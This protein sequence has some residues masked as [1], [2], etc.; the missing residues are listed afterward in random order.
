MKNLLVITLCLV[1]VIFFA[2]CGKENNTNNTPTSTTSNNQENDIQSSDAEGA[3]DDLGISFEKPEKAVSIDTSL[4]DPSNE[5]ITFG[6]DD[7]GKVLRC[8]Y[9]Y[10]DQIIALT[11]TYNDDNTVQIYGFIDSTLVV[12]TLVNLPGEYNPKGTFVAIDG[13]YFKGF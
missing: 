7:N 3:T 4:A 2:G 9:L 6:Y 10:N 11:Y 12:D 13:F 8:Q 5:K 1:M